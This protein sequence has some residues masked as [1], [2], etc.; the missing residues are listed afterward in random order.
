MQRTV[1]S[2]SALDSGMASLLERRDERPVFVHPVWLQT[3]LSE[4]G[5]RC[6]PCLVIANGSEMIGAAPLMRVEERLTFIGDASICD[7]MD[8]IIDPDAGE[9]A[10]AAL[11]RQIER[12]AW[13]ELDLWGLPAP[14]PTREAI[15]RLAES[16]GLQVQEEREAVAPRI[17]LPASWEEYLASLG[18]KDRHELRRKLRR[19][20]ESGGSV[21]L[22]VLQDQADVAAAMP[23]FLELHT[24]SRLDKMGFMTDGMASFFRRMAS[25]LAAEG[26]VRLFMLRINARP[27]AAVLCFDAGSSL[28]L[29]NSG[30]DP[31]FSGLSVGLVSKALCIRW[32]IDNGKRT[33]DFL[34][35]NEA[36]KYDLGAADQ[37]IYRVVVRRQ[38]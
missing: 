21:N 8:F 11:W 25:A 23:T 34:R 20:F 28:Y 37:E 3:W 12:E 31:A 16:A 29:Y 22:E 1:S 7:Y 33:L 27:A 35:G 13:E 32:A 18:K 15:K 2:L 38:A 17:T 26:L 36:Y 5:D 19:V 9:Q 10:Y 4:F 24:G 6:E 30:Y 14:S